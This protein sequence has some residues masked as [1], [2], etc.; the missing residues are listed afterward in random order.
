MSHALV[1]MKLNHLSFPSHDPA[2]TAAFFETYLGFTAASAPGHW[3]LKRPGFDIVIED[4]DANAPQWPSNFHVGFELPSRSDV[5][6]LYARMLAD[7]VSME[8]DVIEHERGSRFFCRAPVG[9]MF[10]LN[11]RADAAPEYRGTFD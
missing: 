2:S 5:E 10:E 9:V 1:P 6:S 4:V 8:T 11:T 7:G 3:I